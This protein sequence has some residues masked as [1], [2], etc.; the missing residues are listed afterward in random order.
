MES[1]RRRRAS[2]QAA[3]QRTIVERAE[4]YFRSHV[5]VSLQPLCGIMGVSERTL[6]NAF[7]KVR[8]MSPKRCMLRMRLV[9]AHEALRHRVGYTT[10]TEVATRCGFF[11]LGRFAQRYKAAFGERPSDTLRMPGHLGAALEGMTGARSDHAR[12]SSHHGRAGMS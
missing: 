2:Q 12:S 1:S 4:R 7:Y 10:V 6:R 9:E 8:G 3:F 5:V 11:E